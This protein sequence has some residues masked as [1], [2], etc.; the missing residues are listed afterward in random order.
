MVMTLMTKSE[1]LTISNQM[2]ERFHP[3]SRQQFG[4]QLALSLNLNS[5]TPCHRG[6]FNTIIY[7]NPNPFSHKDKHTV[8]IESTHLGICPADERT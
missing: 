5:K 2:K 4:W 3:N 8:C 7:K 1:N 6:R